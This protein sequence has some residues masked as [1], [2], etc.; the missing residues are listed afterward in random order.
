MQD[1]RYEEYEGYS[2]EEDR[3]EN[4]LDAATRYIGTRRSIRETWDHLGEG[5]SRGQL[6]SLAKVLAAI[7]AGFLVYNIINFVVHL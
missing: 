7:A 5:M 1:D 6:S 3:K 2:Q 4:P